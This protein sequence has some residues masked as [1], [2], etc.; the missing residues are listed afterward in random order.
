MTALNAAVFGE[1][2]LRLTA[3]G[4]EALLQSGRLE[5]W[6]GGAEA[7]VAAGLASLGHE[8]RIITALPGNTIGQ[9]C[10]G[11]LR[12]NGLDTRHV[13]RGEGR[14][15][16]YFHTSGAMRRPAEIVYDRAHSAFCHTAPERWDWG[17][18]LDGVSWLHLSGITPALGAGPARAALDAASAA[19][20][21]GA[22]VS[23]D[24]NYRPML[25][26]GREGEAAQVLR[27]LAAHVTLL[28]ASAG[29]L[30]RMVEFEAGPDPDLSL[31]AGAKAAFAAFPDLA[32]IA[33]TFRVSRGT[34]DQTLSARLISRDGVTD[35]GPELMD[36]IVE[37]IGGGDAF[38]AGL[39]DGLARGGARE[40]ALADALTLM[41]VK[42][43]MPG[44]Q[45]KVRRE[46]IA[47]WR[48]GRDLKR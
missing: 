36:G 29:D 17:R 6:F 38:A 2:L 4:R 12:R 26:G 27:T 45:C 15:G 43:S 14:M 33:T 39:I 3:P 37:R 13:L 40:T 24:V 16:L 41:A 31:A 22:Q 32:H 35:A 28:F 34:L 47:A 20:A 46:D 44:D 23:F 5:A 8:A 30:A 42:H 9:G 48:E 21:R 19:R 11:E 10:L 1:V 7:N 25:W 18:A